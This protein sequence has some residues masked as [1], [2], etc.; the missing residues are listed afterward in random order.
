M[1]GEN[2]IYLSQPILNNEPLNPNSPYRN[3]PGT[4]DA[5]FGTGRT[6]NSGATLERTSSHEFGHSGTLA[7]PNAGSSPG[8]LM[9]QT[10]KPDAGMKV[11]KSQILQMERAYKTGGLN[12]RKQ[13]A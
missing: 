11:N 9:N 4:N 13:K 3:V 6:N 1:F 2:I 12:H 7:H 8:N 5:E 10:G